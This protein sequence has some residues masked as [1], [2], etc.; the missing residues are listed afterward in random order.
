MWSATIPTSA[1]RW[2]TPRRGPSSTQTSARTLASLLPDP[3][4]LAP[5]LPS[6]CAVLSLHT[7]TFTC[8]CT[9]TCTFTC[10][11]MCMQHVPVAQPRLVRVTCPRPVPDPSTQVRGAL[12]RLRRPRC[13][14]RPRALAALRRA[15][16]RRAARRLPRER[17][18]ALARR[19][20]PLRPQGR[21][22]ARPAVRRLFQE[23]ST[24]PLESSNL[25]LVGW[26]WMK[27]FWR[28]RRT[29][30]PRLSDTRPSPR[31]SDTRW[32]A[33]CRRGVALMSGFRLAAAAAAA[34]VGRPAGWRAADGVCVA[35]FLVA[36]KATLSE[37]FRA[38]YESLRDAPRDAP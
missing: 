29:R 5:A 36:A 7:C 33:L 9:C 35:V 34:A 31:P 6:R 28:L 25:A 38:V 23:P 11:Y 20:Q 14:R 12:S 27:R 3:P 17:A 19:S 18:L 37:I 32:H 8:T 1:P 10:T 16:L 30:R 26:L 2:T 24:S 21:R 4:P 13:P 22:R 15:A